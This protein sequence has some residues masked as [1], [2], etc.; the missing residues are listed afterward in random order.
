MTR[1]NYRNGNKGI[2]YA[3]PATIQYIRRLLKTPTIIGRMTVLRHG[4]AGGSAVG[5]VGLCPHNFE[6]NTIPGAS[7]IMLA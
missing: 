5:S 6:H 7:G 4:G 3:K 1:N 2:F